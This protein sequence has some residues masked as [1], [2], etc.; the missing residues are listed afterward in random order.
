MP[1]TYPLMAVT[2]EISARLSRTTG[3]EVTQML[4]GGPRWPYVVG[5]GLTCVA[6]QIVLQYA[7]YVAVLKWLT[8]ALFAYFGTVLIVDIP[9]NEALRGLLA[10]T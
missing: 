10:P 8:L 1:F 4:I 6:L 5:F 9:G 7:R 3:D 2:Q